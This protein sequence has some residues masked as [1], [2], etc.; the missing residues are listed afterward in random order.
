MARLTRYAARVAA[1]EARYD[2]NRMHFRT[3]RGRRFSLDFGDVFH[4]VTDTLGWLHDPD[5]EQPRGPI[6]ELLA[7]AE[8]DKELGL[9]GQTVVL[10]AK[11][12]VTG[13]R[14]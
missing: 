6:L 14:P 3:S 2:A 11:Q 13:V 5:A 7:T 9:I 8:P 10:A 1:L 4:I 12:A